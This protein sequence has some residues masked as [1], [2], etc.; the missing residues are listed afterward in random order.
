METATGSGATTV[1][2]GASSSIDQTTS[3]TSTVEEEDNLW[4]SKKKQARP[5][6]SKNDPLAP[7]RTPQVLFIPSRPRTKPKWY[8]QNTEQ[9]P[10]ELD[11]VG[12]LIFLIAGTN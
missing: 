11:T 12:L 7:V 10:S 1:R 4:D 5:T 8:N 9:K 3:T 2:P 6:Y